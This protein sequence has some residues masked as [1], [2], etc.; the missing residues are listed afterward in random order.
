MVKEDLV[1]EYIRVDA[2]IVLTE[3]EKTSLF[4]RYA[5]RFSE[6]YGY[7]LSDVKDSMAE[8]VYEAMLY[9]KTI[10][11]LIVHNTFTVAE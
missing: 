2:D 8:L 4:D 6:Q 3:Q 1:Y 11:Y 5:E 7:A 10:E 9:D